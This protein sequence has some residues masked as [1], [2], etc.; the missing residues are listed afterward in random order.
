[1]FSRSP[2]A[3]GEGQTLC[4]SFLWIPFSSIVKIE[5]DQRPLRWLENLRGS[6]EFLEKVITGDESWIY[7]YNIELKSQSREWKQKDSPR[8]KK[9][10]KSKSKIKVMLVFVT[11]MELCT[12]NLHL[13]VKLSTQ[14]SMWRFWS[15][16]EIV[17][18]PCDRNFGR[19]GDGF[20]TTTM[21]PRTLH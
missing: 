5:I 3:L 6:I 19:G 20:S 11:A 21:P 17:C 16:W 15:I 18:I 2:T 10:R 4:V 1:M 13:R 9:S 8:P 7:K 12:T 14:L